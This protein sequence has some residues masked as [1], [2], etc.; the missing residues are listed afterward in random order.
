MQRYLA[1]RLI[2][3]IPTLFG[4]S[5]VVF[6][7]MRLLPGDAI[8]AM[9]GTSFKLTDAQIAALR[10]YFGFDKP[11]HE[12]YWIWLTAALRGDFGFSVRSGIPVLPEILA[13]FP[14]TLE[15]AI[16]AMLIATTIGIPIGILAAVQRDSTLDLAG[17]LFALI[18]LA[19]PNFWMGT[20]I[21]LVLSV[22]FGVLPTSG[23]YT[24]FVQ[25]P[26][27]NLKQLFFPALTLGFAFSASVMRTTRS[28]MLEELRQDYTRTARGKGLK[29]QAVIVGHCLKNALI[30][31]ITIIGL[32]TG[33][34]FGGAIIVEEVFALPGIGRYLLTG[35]AQ[36]DY[37][38]VQGTV[39]FIAFNFVL[40]NLIADLAYA[41]VNPR[42]R[43]D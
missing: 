4:I 41:F 17:R 33:Y 42:I 22:A 23:D 26:V 40:I 13:R 15:L 19:L 31:I 11:L 35:I 10:A 32:E 20:L 14:L 9:V 25:D 29:E 2:A 1:Q 38:V 3:F 34:L 21:I 5:I 24:D 37:A 8:N 16:L 36:R 30:P 39:I 12:Q 43:Y 18:G 7:V 28:S 27:T 6:I